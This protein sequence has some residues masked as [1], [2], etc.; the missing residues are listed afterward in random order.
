MSYY[1][2]IIDILQDYINE[3]CCEN[4]SKDI[5]PPKFI[6]SVSEDL[7]EQKILLTIDHLGH[8]FTNVLF[9]RD[10]S[11]YGYSGLIEMMK[12]M[13]NRTM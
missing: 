12:N 13:Y 3:Y 9:P 10:D 8:A 4:Y 7:D 5:C 6:V 1:K 2:S 11:Y